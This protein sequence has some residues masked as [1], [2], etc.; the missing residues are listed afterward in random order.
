MEPVA[1]LLA[2]IGADTSG[3]TADLGKAEVSLR[4][5]A[6]VTEKQAGKASQAFAGNLNAMGQAAGAAGG[7]LASLNVAAERAANGGLSNMDKAAGR[8]IDSAGKMRSASGQFVSLA[9]Q[10]AEAAGKFGQAGTKAAFDLDK[11]AKA[12]DSLKN[13]GQ[14]LTVGVTAPIVAAGV[15]AG[16][17][18]IEFESAFAGVKKTLDTA[19]LSATETTTEYA[20]L[21]AGIRELAQT[22]PAT[23]TEIAGVA[24]AAGQLGIK[25]ES[26]LGFTKVMIDLGNSTNLAADQAAT[27][28]ARLANITGLPQDQF[29]NLGSAIVALGNNFATTEAEITEMGLRIAGAGKQV[30]LSEAQVLGFAAALSSVGIE[31]EAGGTAFSTVLKKIQVSAETGG[32]DLEGFARVAGVSA[33]AFKKAF[34][35]D[36]AGATISFIEGLGKIKEQGGSTIQTLAG[37]DLAD[38]RV[39]DSLLRLSGAGDLARRSVQLGSEAFK[40]N[41]AL[42]KEAGQRYE[43]TASQIQLAKNRLNDLGITLGNSLLPLTR[44]LA[45]AV[46]TVADQ[47][48]A[49]SPETLRF[50]TGLAAAAAAVG[51]LLV[52]IGSLGAAIPALV[53][54]FGTVGAA[55]GLAAGPLALVVVAVA[56]ATVAIIANWDKIVK[57]FEGPD[58]KIFQDLGRSVSESVGLIKDV[59][60]SLGGLGN[61]FAETGALIGETIHVLAVVVTGLLDT[62]VGVV[63]TIDGLLTGDWAKAWDGAKQ[64]VAGVAGF[65]A[66][67]FGYD[68]AALR[69]SL[70]ILG[71]KPS[72]GI[73]GASVL[74]NE[75]IALNAGLQGFLQVAEEVSGL[76]GGDLAASLE[77]A[78]KAA[79]GLTEA[80]SK[81]LQKLRES[82]SQAG[83]LSNALGR[84]KGLAA[85]GSDYDFVQAKIKALEESIPALVAAFGSQAGVVRNTVSELYRLKNAYDDLG[86]IELR[87][88]AGVSL[89]KV[90][91]PEFA[92]ETELKVPPLNTADYDNSVAVFEGTALRI[93]NTISNLTL[94]ELPPLPAFD[95]TGLSSSVDMSIAEMQRLYE[96][97][98]AAESFTEG[99]NNILVNGLAD[100]AAGFGEGIGN[101]LAGAGGLNDLGA[102]VLGALGGLAIQ[103]GQLA[104]ATGLAV[105]GIKAALETLNPVVAIAGGIALVALGTA[106]KGIAKGIGGSGRAPSLPSSA[107][108]GGTA[109]P[110]SNTRQAPITIDLKLQPVEL[111]QKGPDMAGVLA[112]ESYRQRRTQ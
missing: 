56:G 71:D 17:S 15:L 7:S 34:Q 42:A 67:L 39:S 91:V 38:I 84:D 13:L 3:L 21:S 104:I 44:G 102:I 57:Y 8:F 37:L 46:G 75:F 106:V 98:L 40:E 54:G 5:F 100:I 111:R 92:F 41:T 89:P 61:P 1:S 32:K 78:G 66:E 105:A 99:L 101:I 96:A 23:T 51:P 109:A 49:M 103:V 83:S 53:T 36:A 110:N 59:F 95:T 12:G 62:V 68:Y 31:A 63:R 81:A 27:S 45:S 16:K 30:G 55:V 112:F 69:N 25:R 107:S 108:A 77:K 79:A 94:P 50:A 29:E 93:A 18:A 65:V 86:T 64:S 47:L 24:E 28:L 82:L 87:L 72:V 43:T 73:E 2:V 70:N 97:Q 80:Q 76:A 33:A 26:V 11:L 88:P 10:A 6:A 60:S 74:T 35:T 48:K 14:T 4:Q 58:G 22:I 20:K 19:G 52:G 85:I 9:T 90:E